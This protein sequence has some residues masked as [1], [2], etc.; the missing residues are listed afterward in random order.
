MKVLAIG[1]HYDDVEIGCGGT[2]AMHSLKQDTVWVLVI[3]E[4][5]Y[6]DHKSKQIRH[7]SVAKR[8]GVKAAKALNVK[9][10]TTLDFPTN[11][12]PFNEKLVLSVRTVI[13]DFKPDIVYS[14]WLGDSHLDHYHVAR[15]TFS[16][17]RHVPNVFTYQSNW[18]K[19]GVAFNPRYYV[20]I[21]KTFAAKVKSLKAYREEFLRRG[22]DWM[23]FIG[24]TNGLYGLECGGNT[25]WAEGFE[26]IKMRNKNI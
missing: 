7:S 16:A 26:V 22:K 6:S 8:E 25:R 23:R 12:I 10:T 5:G 20:D 4:S 17:C 18:Y 24:C 2:L 13:D 3:S 19:G 15:A 21:S 14:H 1:A 9:K 11:D